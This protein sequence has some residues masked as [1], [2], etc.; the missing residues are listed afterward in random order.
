MGGGYLGQAGD[1]LID[2][3]VR[4]YA[5]AVLLRFLLQ[6]A[7][8]DFRNPFAQAILKVTTPALRPLRKV[9]PGWKGHD[10]AALVL[11][12][13]VMALG[14]LLQSWLHGFTPALPGLLLLAVGRALDLA[15][16]L[17]VFLLILLAVMSFVAPGGYSPLAVLMHRLAEPLLAPL[18]PL[19]PP[20]GGIDFTPLAAIIGLQLLRILLVQPVLDLGRSLM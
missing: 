8:A 17:Y 12:V 15:V 5:A 2:T 7:R 4:L 1:F 16:T 13:A 6:F 3:A 18:R 9:V 11:L 20:M 19:L 14:V 10:L